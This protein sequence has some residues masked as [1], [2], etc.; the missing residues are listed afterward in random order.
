MIF[1]LF[2]EVLVHTQDIVLESSNFK[3]LTV[4]SMI[5][6]LKIISSIFI[7]FFSKKGHLSVLDEY[8]V[9]LI[10]S[11]TTLSREIASE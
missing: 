2:G 11:Y 8:F 7:P 1:R 5:G 3:I 6:K 4:N 10:Q 9:A